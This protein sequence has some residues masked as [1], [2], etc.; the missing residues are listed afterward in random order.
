MI[1]EA[2]G[3][4]FDFTDAIDAFIFDEKDKTSPHYHGLPMKGV[5]IIVV[6]RDACLFVELKDL[7]DPASY[8]E[9][10]ATENDINDALQRR[11]TFNWL[12]NYLKYKYRDT[13]L[14]RHAE[15]QIDHTKPLHYICVLTF[16]N[17]LNTRLQK[18]L[19]KE[20]PVGKASKRWQFEIAR[21]VQVMNVANWNKNFPK[22]PLHHQRLLPA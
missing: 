18:T 8:D 16:E 2:D 17:A 20:L 5:D 6:L 9:M 4:S 13:Y 7:N 11:Q 10:M 12:K 21:S 1:I 15:N 22:W 14:C 3:F 19:K